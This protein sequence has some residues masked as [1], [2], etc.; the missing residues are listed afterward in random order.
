MAIVYAKVGIQGIRPL[1]WHR[2][3]P[4]ALPLEKRA[5]TGVA[6]N[7]PEEWKRTVLTT[8]SRQLYLEPAYVFGCLR[9]A[10]KY[11]P[12]R[13]GTL[14]PILASTLQVPGDQILVDRWL[15]K[16]GFEELKQAESEPVYLD[17]RSVRNPSTRAR[18][19]RYRVA[20]S[21]GWKTSFIL[22]WENTLVSENEMKAILRDAGQFVG[23][24]DGRNIG[25][26]RFNIS[27]F[28]VSVKDNATKQ[29]TRGHLERN[30]AENLASRRKEV[31]TVRRRRRAQ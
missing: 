3:G 4:D 18:N 15:P 25:F 28:E 19:V 8:A 1:M 31:Q 14:Q 7:D 5:K 16:D 24:G 2:F 30:P 23:L 29:A 12:R 22:I 10:A 11:T 26:G 9:D 6:G 17:I 20:A 21:P 27:S 13:R